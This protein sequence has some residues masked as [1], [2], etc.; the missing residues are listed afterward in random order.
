MKRT[1]FLNRNLH[2]AFPAVIK[3][4]GN[5]LYLADGRIVFDATSGTAVSCL[6]YNNTRVIEAINNQLN[7]GLSYLSST[8]WSCDIVDELCKELINGTGQQMRRV[9][10]TG[11]GSCLYSGMNLEHAANSSRIR[12][13]G[14]C[15]KTRSAV[16]L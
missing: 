8:F 4:E 6:G 1:E 11:S 10:L 3:G 14:S 7:T 16:L 12:S 15:F 9:Y 2:K 5:Y 13:N